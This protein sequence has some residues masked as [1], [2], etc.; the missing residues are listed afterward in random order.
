MSKILNKNYRCTKCGYETVSA[1]NHFGT[2]WSFGR[3]NVC[4]KCPPY[5]K[6][7]EFGGQTIWECMDVEPS[8]AERLKAE[9]ETQTTTA[10]RP[11]K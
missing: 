1:T 4:P 6:Y 7:P 9:R 8:E 3:F 10:D 11:P 5:A 2:T